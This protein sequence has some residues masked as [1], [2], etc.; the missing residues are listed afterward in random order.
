MPSGSV[1]VLLAILT[2]DV[3][4]ADEVGAVLADVG[5]RHREPATDLA[6]HANGVLVGVRCAHAGI[7]QQ[8]LLGIDDR[9][10][11][12]VAA[13]RGSNAVVVTGVTP[14]W[15]ALNSPVSTPWL[16]RP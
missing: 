2:A 15:K 4:P 5:D 12:R 10:E 9:D 13:G 3:R 14:G 6:I 11:A 7:E 1:C 16:N 8:V